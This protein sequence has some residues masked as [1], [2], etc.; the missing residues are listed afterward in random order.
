MAILERWVLL[1]CLILS[2][3]MALYYA[4]L[5]PR[6]KSPSVRR[7]L[8]W[9]GVLPSLVLVTLAAAVVI[10]HAVLVPR[11]RVGKAQGQ[12]LNQG[13]RQD[14]REFG[15]ETASGIQTLATLRGNVVVVDVWATWCP[16]CIAGI[17]R[18]VAL[19]DKYRGRP[20]RVIG[21]SVDKNGW[22]DVRPFLT[23]HPEIDYEMAV[24]NPKPSFQVVTIVDLK[25]LGSVAAV[26]TVFVV[27]REGKLAAKFVGDDRYQEIDEFVAAVL[28]E[29]P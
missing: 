1:V 17:P 29:E 22:A 26:P 24:P 15:F 25:P 3:A 6:V 13:S 23:K 20:V 2:A 27:D 18:V 11:I 21:L 9:L 28:R 5:V 7:G 12:F 8:K 19:T 16:P 4:V 14:V 10:Y